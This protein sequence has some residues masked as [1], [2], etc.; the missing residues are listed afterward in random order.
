MSREFVFT[1]EVDFDKIQSKILEIVREV[2]DGK[3]DNDLNKSGINRDPSIDFTKDLTVS[4]NQGLSPQE[5][6][7]VIVVFGPLA[8]E[9]AKDI[10]KIIVVPKLKRAFR[11]DRVSQDD[12]R[13]Q[14]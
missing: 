12:K 1:R 7:E 11:S 8:G 3:H 5:W 4:I 6:S 9:V 13:K 2:N 14:K 10:W